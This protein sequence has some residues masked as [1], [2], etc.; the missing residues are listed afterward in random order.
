LTVADA[1]GASGLDAREAR[2]L[3]A[4]ASGFSQAA[5]LA[6]PGRALSRE[7]AERFADFAARRARGEPVAYIVGYQEFYGLRLAVNPVALIP[8]PETEL[9]VD[10]ALERPWRSAVDLGA[11]CGAIAL[12]LKHERPG[13]HVVGTD[14]SAAALAL[15]RRNATALALG[16]EW[17][18][19]RWCEPLQGERYELIV[20]N[21][22][23][24]ACGDPHLAA[25][26]YEPAHALIAGA[27][28]LD[29]LRDIARAAPPHLADGGWLLLEHGYDQANMVRE[30]LG[31]AGLHDVRSWPDLA[32]ILRVSG[33]RR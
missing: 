21:P 12:A 18:H 23:Y 7:A 33:G 17:R 27:D 16:I 30:L 20:S 31:A 24:V 19:G 14:A 9:L 32:G 22:P 25:L 6:F 26:A 5:L 3:L 2:L 8:R 11:G 28:G 29:A 1:L 4:A 15:A 13:A 10:L